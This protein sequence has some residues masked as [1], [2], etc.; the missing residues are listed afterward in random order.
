METLYY[1]SKLFVECK[2]NNGILDAIL[3]NSASFYG[4]N[5]CHA[6]LEKTPK[7]KNKKKKKKKKNKPQNSLIRDFTFNQKQFQKELGKFWKV[8]Y[9]H[10]FH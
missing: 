6:K 1:L 9:F 3:E 4:S 8:L 2:T 5:C 10:K 7:K